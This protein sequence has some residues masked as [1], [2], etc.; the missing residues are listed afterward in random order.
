MSLLKK[1]GES[2]KKA[3]KAFAEE[4]KTKEEIYRTKKHILNK[5]ELKDLKKICKAYGIGKPSP[6]EEDIITGERRRRSLTRGHYI[7][8]VIFRLSLEQIED[9]CNRHKID[10]WDIIKER[11]KREPKRTE[12]IQEKPREEK[13]TK[14]EIK[15]QPEFE[16]I[17]ETIE[18]EFQ[19]IVCDI[20]IRDENELRKQLVIFLRTKLS[21]KIEEE[22]NTSKGR[23]DILIDR[24][25][26]LELKYADNKGTLEKGIA[27]LKR[28]GK[29]FDNIVFIILD[30]NKL[31][32]STIREYKN[33]YEEDGAEVIILRGRGSRKKKSKS[34][35]IIIGN[36]RIKID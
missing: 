25:Y 15:R 33:Y 23:I 31:S 13:I 30:T 24:K 6:Y 4:I 17:L 35:Q 34:T 8:Y 19:N 14:I 36:K 16:S 22:Y 18:S 29:Q 12:H 9:F 10:I 1:I 27:E 5:F 2:V 7:N 28:Y 21:N 26:V 32:F 20:K 11:E 3:G